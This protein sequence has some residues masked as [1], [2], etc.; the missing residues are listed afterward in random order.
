MN[1]VDIINL[2]PSLAVFA[3]DLS[4]AYGTAKA[5]RRRNSIPSELWVAVVSAAAKRGIV[6]VDYETLARA[7]ARPTLAA[8][9]AQS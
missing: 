6:G 7:V 1:H 5:M 8:A 3:E 2:W 9:E 4:M